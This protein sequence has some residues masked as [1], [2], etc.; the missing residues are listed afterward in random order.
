MKI[1][2]SLAWAPTAR[3][4]ILSR[5][6]FFQPIVLTSLALLLPIPTAAILEKGSG[7]TVKIRLENAGDTLG[8]QIADSKLRGQDIV[9]VQRVMNNRAKNLEEGMVLRDF[10][11]S[12]QLLKRIKSGPYPIELEFINVAAGGDALS[13]LGTTIVTP[14]DALDLAKQTDTTTPPQSTVN[15]SIT[16]IAGPASICAIQ[17]R[18]GDVLEIQYEAAYYYLPPSGDEIRRIV[19]DNS[20]S[21]GTGQPYL[22]VLGSGDMIP[23]VDQGL[24]DMCPGEERLLEIPPLLAYGKRA[25]DSFGIPSSYMKL[26][27]R[28]KL[29]S[30]DSNIRQDENSQTR[31][32]R[33]GRVR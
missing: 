19:Y 31:E 21:R 5:R 27:W 15:Y 25:R 29:M 18:R 24:Y 11:N 16:K 13:D 7:M 9:V 14:K 3:D 1:E 8:L 4:E 10:E 26:E 33:E 12:S 28:V 20:S 2:L 32:E 22:M 30:I 17:S 23:G 6:N